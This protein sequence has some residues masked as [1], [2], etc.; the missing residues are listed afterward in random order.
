MDDV[1][2]ASPRA[3]NRSRIIAQAAL[4]LQEQGVAAVTTR[5]VAEAAGVQPPTIYRLFG[6]KDGLLDAVAE[7][8][9]AAYV[10]TKVTDAE[11]A[12]D[13]VMDPL[14]DL[15]AGWQAQIRFGLA[16]PDLF[17]LL[18]DPARATTS[19]AVRAGI[20]V[21]VARV[22]RLAAAQ[23]LRVGEDDAVRLIHAGGTGAVL[24]TLALP[25]DERTTQ[26]ADAMFDAVCR[27]ILTET[28]PP[29]DA[30]ILPAANALRAAAATELNPLTPNE[31]N[32]LTE[33]LD[34]ISDHAPARAHARPSPSPGGE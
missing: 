31:R 5:G 6:D 23:R 30:G 15:R 3:E 28:E 1:A 8:V 32:L 22:R 9:M 14:E 16:N 27:S 25:P 7:H 4:L 33:W 12:L 19:P 21:L 29:A 17:V 18:S 34:R 26:I 11:N 24:A 13:A 20:A 2:E 10:T